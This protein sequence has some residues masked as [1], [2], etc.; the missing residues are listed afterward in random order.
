MAAPD[1]NYQLPWL[2]IVR[3]WFIFPVIKCTPKSILKSSIQC[4]FSWC[5]KPLLLRMLYWYFRLYYSA[6]DFYFI[7]GWLQLHPLPPHN[8]ETL[9][10][11]RMSCFW[12]TIMNN[13][14][15]MYKCINGMICINLMGHPENRLVAE[16]NSEC[17]WLYLCKYWWNFWT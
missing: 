12:D 9:L 11:S 6:L 16:P 10:I 2:L 7:L 13:T 15:L 4:A 3:T 1:Y 5:A 8:I 17:I 14:Y